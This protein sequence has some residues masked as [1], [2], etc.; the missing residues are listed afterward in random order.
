[1]YVDNNEHMTSCTT[2]IVFSLV[3]LPIPIYTSKGL[4]YL[5]VQKDTA[6]NQNTGG[7]V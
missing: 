2:M 4:F 7:N 6:M 5:W 1:M 3:T